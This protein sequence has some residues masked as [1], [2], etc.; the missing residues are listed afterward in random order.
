GCGRPR[1]SGGTC[2][3]DPR[4]GAGGRRKV[5]NG[6]VR[7][8]GL[9]GGACDEPGGADGGAVGRGPAAEGDG[10]AGGRTGPGGHGAGGLAGGG[11]APAQGAGRLSDSPVRRDAALGARL[12]RTWR[13]LSARPGGAWL[14]SR[15]LGR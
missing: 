10:P 12:L 13:R 7:P 6:R 14:F 1:G 5:E 8:G 4:G 15:L 2:G 11:G 3:E 9:A